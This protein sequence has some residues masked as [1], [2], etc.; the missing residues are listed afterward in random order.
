MPELQRPD[1]A[2]IH[3]EERGEGPLIVM[4]LQFFGGAVVFPGLISELAN[5]HRVVTYDVRGV[6]A[7]SPQGPYDQETD[8][9]DLIALIEELGGPALLIPMA[10]G[11]NRAVRVAAERPDLAV[12][13][14][15]P[16]G[17]PVGR[18]G[19]SGHRGTGRIRLRRRGRHGHGGDRL[20]RSPA[21]AVHERQSADERRPATRSRAGDDRL[22]PAGRSRSERMRNWVED[23]AGDLGANV[24]WTSVAAGARDQSLVSA[25]DCRADAPPAAGGSHRG[26]RGRGDL[27]TRHHRRVRAADPAVAGTRS[28]QRA[29]SRRSRSS[30]EFQAPS[31]AL[32][33]VRPGIARTTTPSRSSLRDDRAR[34]AADVEDDEVR[35]LAGNHRRSARRVAR[36]AGPRGRRCGRRPPASRPARAGRCVASRPALSGPASSPLSKR[37]APRARL[38][39]ER[40]GVLVERHVARVGDARAGRSTRGSRTARRCRSGRR[41]TSGRRR[42]RSCSRSPRRRSGAFRAPGRRRPAAARRSRP[43]ARAERP[44]RS[45]R[46]RA[47]RRSGSWSHR[48]A[49]RDRRRAPA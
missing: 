42:R 46:R 49:I 3:W 47:R 13:V 28:P 17:N 6:G 25:C 44:S 20:P 4:A 10:D 34:V 9:H 48:R 32:I 22:L 41:A 19:G 24:G 7:S 12:A 36:A 16:G 26:G 40:I 14:L 35:R 18:R 11:V 45:S 33:Q 23:D 30:S 5:D 31:E 21:R 1:G 8:K 39:L 38:Q 43:A 37:A 27:A 15:T 29:A 2:T